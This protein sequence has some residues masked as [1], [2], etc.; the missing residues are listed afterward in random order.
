MAKND[1]RVVESV[2]SSIHAENICRQSLLA[3]FGGG[4]VLDAVGFAASI[5]LR[6]VKCCVS[7]H[8]ARSR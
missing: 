5:A 1:P 7:D 6:N 8:H 2:L 4:A 3:I